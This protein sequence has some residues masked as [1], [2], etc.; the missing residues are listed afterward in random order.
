MIWEFNI[1][2]I[3]MACRE[4][5]MGKKKCEIYWP[6][7]L[8]ETNFFFLFQQDSEESKG[9]YLTRTLRSSNFFQCSRTLKQ[10]HYVNWPDHGV[11]DSI[12]PI[13]DM[14]YEMRSFQPHDDIPICIHCR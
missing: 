11:P 2:V 8:G 3:V 12:P 9:D 10:L 14:L 6:Q 1:Q 4:F 13:L 5:E 7:T